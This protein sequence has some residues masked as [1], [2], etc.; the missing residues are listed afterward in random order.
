MAQGDLESERETW[1]TRAIEGEQRAAIAANGL[2]SQL[3]TP[4][5]L[6]GE[7]AMFG[8]MN[9]QQIRLDAAR[10]AWGF[11]ADARNTENQNRADRFAS[12]GRN[13]ATIMGALASSA[14]TAGNAGY[15]GS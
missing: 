13:Q 8:E 2:D 6:L 9:Q 10:K 15:F 1:R 3:G 7:T 11:N 5:E 14:K 4:N 12:K